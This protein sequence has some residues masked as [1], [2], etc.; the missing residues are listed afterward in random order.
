VAWL[1]T[2]P[3]P[4]L[5]LSDIQLAD[6]LSFQVFDQLQVPCPVV[7]VTAYDAYLL[8]AFR[9]DGIDY[10]L[11]PVGDADVARALDKYQRLREH[12]A[13]RGLG[14]FL[15]EQRGHRQRVLVRRGGEVTAVPV[16]RIAYLRADRK[17]VVLVERDGRESLIERSLNDLQQEL[18][19]RSSFRASRQYLVHLEAIRSFR[20]YFKGRLLLEMQPP[21]PG[22]VV[23]S[24]ESAPAF[25]ACLDR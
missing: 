25:R 21:P 20:P 22:E 12:F 24:A 3:A 8:E 11:K 4:D 14:A 9:H 18:D 7:F 19:P 13:P 16:G 15:Q 1:R 23:V 17:L 10:L 2:H 6:G 5:L